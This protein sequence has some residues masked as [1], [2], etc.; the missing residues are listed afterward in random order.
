MGLAKLRCVQLVHTRRPTEGG[1]DGYAVLDT[2]ELRAGKLRSTQVKIGRLDDK[3]C[4]RI[5]RYAL[6]RI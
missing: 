3:L 5:N 6:M 4:A 1:L 2:A